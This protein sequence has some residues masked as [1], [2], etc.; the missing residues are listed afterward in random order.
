MVKHRT[1]SREDKGSTPPPAV[2][3]LGQFRLP[4]FLCL[5]VSM[6]G[7]VKGKWKK[8]VVDS[9]T[10]EKENSEN[11]FTMLAIDRQLFGVEFHKCK[12]AA[13]S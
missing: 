3:K 7:E 10:V 9:L 2:S 4:H 6:A 8:P 5:S 1:V 12:N 13:N 11:N